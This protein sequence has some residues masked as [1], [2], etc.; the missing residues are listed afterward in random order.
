VE[1]RSALKEVLLTVLPERT[2]L[3]FMEMK[4]KLG[5]QHKFPRVMKG[6]MLEDWQQFISSVVL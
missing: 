4:G 1:R 6:K 2:F 3:E 5:G